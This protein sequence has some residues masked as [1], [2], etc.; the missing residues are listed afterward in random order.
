MADTTKTAGQAK[1]AFGSP[2]ILEFVST[3]NQQFLTTLVNC[4]EE[5]DIASHLHALYA[6]ALTDQ[7]ASE[8]DVIIFQ[9]L[10]FVH[11]HFLFATSSYMRCHMAEGFSSARAAIDGALI[12][13]QIIHDRDSQSAYL[14]RTKPF[15]KL[16]RHFKNLIRDSKPLP[17]PLVPH[18]IE[19]HDHCSQ[20]ASHA[21]VATFAHRLEILASPQPML[22]V[23]YFQ[24]PRDTNTMKHHFLGLLH[25]F[26][27]AL[28]VFSNF[29]IDEHKSL[30]GHWRDELRHVGRQIEERQKT[31]L[32]KSA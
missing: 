4:R 11:Y 23:G 20:F 14:N 13:A 25:I 29:L 31:L 18:L 9:F 21:D 5:F 32:P 26:V 30:P 12:G 24:I 15:D 6:A 27:I 17:H 8:R 10:M 16:N 7:E 1:I 3:E 28:D 2:N 19:Q 22:S